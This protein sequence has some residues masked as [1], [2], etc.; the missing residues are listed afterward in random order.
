MKNRHSGE[1]RHLNIAFNWYSCGTNGETQKMIHLVLYSIWVTTFAFIIRLLP[2]LT[3]F[4]S[5]FPSGNRQ[6]EVTY[7]SKFFGD[8]VGK[9]R[10]DYWCTFKNKIFQV[11]KNS[12]ICF[13]KITAPQSSLENPTPRLLYARN[14]IFIWEVI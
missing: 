11:L 2:P 7:V 3:N 6:N 8:G 14:K 12:R 1:R 9:D 13:W 5:C 4:F 10:C